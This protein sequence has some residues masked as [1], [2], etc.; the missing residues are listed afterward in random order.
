[1]A[2]EEDIYQRRGI[3]G[4]LFL[5]APV[6]SILL[7][8]IGYLILFSYGEAGRAADG[9][10]VRM[11]YA[12]CAE[13]RPVVQQRVETMGLPEV[14]FG[15]AEGGFS[16]T[17][18]LPGEPRVRDRIPETLARR[19]R[20]QVRAVVGGAVTEEVIVDQDDIALATVHMAFLDVPRAQ[21]QLTPEASKRLRAHQEQHYEDGVAILVE[22]EVVVE[23]R[24]LPALE[25]GELALD[26]IGRSELERLD[27]AAE[28][29]VILDHRLPC[30]V[31]LVA[32]EE[33]G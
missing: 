33:A 24:N 28:T 9:P 16:V 8:G 31:S 20:L 29:A 14:S 1:M 21:V 10:L 26:P 11:T 25:N 13:A 3:A 23:L 6:V 27:F 2:S 17:A 15:E 32:V 4:L 22:D 30:E 18:R 7:V 19:G 12:G 5:G